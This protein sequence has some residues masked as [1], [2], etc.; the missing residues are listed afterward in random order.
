MAIIGI[1]FGNV[2][3]FPAYVRDMNE[4]TRTGGTELSLLPADPA[5][6]A[7]IPTSFFYSRKLGERY[8]KIAATSSPKANRRNLLKTRFRTSEEI[9]GRMIEYDQVITK[10]IEHIVHLANDTMQKNYMTTSNEIAL[11]YPVHFTMAQVMHLVQLAEEA[12]MPDGTPVKVV[13]TIR[14]PAAAALAYLG[15][16]PH[17]RDKYNVLVYDL[18]GGTFDVAS[19]TVHVKGNW[20]NN[21]LEYYDLVDMDGLKDVGGS[22]FDEAMF[23]LFVRKTGVTPSPRRA[24]DWLLAAEDAKRDLST[25]DV[26]VPML[27]DDYGEP[28][29]LSVTREEFENEV[30]GLIQRTIACTVNL[31][32]KPNVPKP[33]MILLTGGQSQMP[34]IMQMLREA[35]PDY[36]DQSIIIYKPQQ[37]IAYGAARYGVMETEPYQKPR[38][39]EPTQLLHQRTRFD[40]GVADIYDSRGRKYV[41]VLIPAGTEIPTAQDRW[42]SYS[43]AE[44]RRTDLTPIV[45]A[46]R[47]D[48]DLYDPEHFSGR[49]DLVLD[50][51]ETKPAGYQVDLCL[52]VD[53]MGQLQAIV[54]DSRNHQNT[55]DKHYGLQELQ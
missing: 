9:D 42:I 16:L 30:R 40:I 17:P 28:Y 39:D 36:D 54:R 21:T 29:D 34:L 3:S 19:V 50:F 27:E 10:M 14:E 38:K 35:F 49:I 11:S 41:D 15:S 37:A 33:D 5:Y 13:G 46:N 22:K 1:D 24:A 55:I 6:I 32:R 48:P 18:G 45:E 31:A 51:G 53:R 23:N 43:L 47:S 26:V 25:Q 52:Y 2:N 4:K 20:I 12:R 7:G 44:S 8:G